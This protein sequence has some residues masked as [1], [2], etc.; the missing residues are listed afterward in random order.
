[1]KI[2]EKRF[3]TYLIL[4]VRFFLSSTGNKTF[5]LFQ[6]FYTHCIISNNVIFTTYC[7]ATLTTD[8]NSCYLFIF[9]FLVNT[10]SLRYS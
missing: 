3:C 6:T 10:Y 7:R 1:M 4:S 9:L 5:P 8:F 2:I